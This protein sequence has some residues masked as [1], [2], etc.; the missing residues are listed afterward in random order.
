MDLDSSR[1]LRIERWTQLEKKA[2]E[3]FSEE[4]KDGRTDAA[5][6]TAKVCAYLSHRVDRMFFP[7]VKKFDPLD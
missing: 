3:R 1:S 6:R 4:I 2:E 5:A 7:S